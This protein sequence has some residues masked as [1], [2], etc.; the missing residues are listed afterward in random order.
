MKKYP[1]IEIGISVPRLRGE[2]PN[3]KP[4]FKVSDEDILRIITALRLFLPSASINLSTR[5][6]AGT[7]DSLVE[8]GITRMSAGSKTSVGGYCFTGK[9]EAQFDV[10]DDRSA[11]E[12]AAAITKK[13]YDPVFTDWRRI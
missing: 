6:S 7:R 9:T 5:E 3:F 1:A 10:N 12:V 8:N 4:P 13:K 2:N 11:D